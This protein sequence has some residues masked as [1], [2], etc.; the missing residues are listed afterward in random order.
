M[1]KISKSYLNKA[2]IALTIIFQLKSVYSLNHHMLNQHADTFENMIISRTP[3]TIEMIESNSNFIDDEDIELKDSWSL[4]KFN[5]LLKD[6]KSISGP[7]QQYNQF[8]SNCKLIYNEHEDFDVLHQGAVYFILQSVTSKLKY[9][10]K[11][12]TELHNKS[13]F[14]KSDDQNIFTEQD[15]NDKGNSSTNHEKKLLD[16]ISIKDIQIQFPFTKRC[17]I[18]ELNAFVNY[19][20]KNNQ[21]ANS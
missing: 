5:N 1:N 7:D 14:S 9:Y 18:G 6:S 21:I 2:F 11:Y 12:F 8:V 15:L 4:T 3:T 10:S 17:T 20:L 16:Q 13:M 19:I